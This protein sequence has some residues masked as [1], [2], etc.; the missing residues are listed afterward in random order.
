MLGRYH[1]CMLAAVVCVVVFAA[2]PA[3]A[4]NGMR[5]TG[6]TLR[7]LGRGGAFLATEP[8]AGALNGN[9]GALGMLGEP[10]LFFDV[11]LQ[12][13]RVEYEGLLNAHSADKMLWIPNAGY[14]APL[15]DKLA[16][17][18]GVF[19]LANQSYALR[20]FDLSLLGAPPGTSDEASSGVRYLAITPGIAVKLSEDT[21]VGAALNW[22]SG[23]T[24][25][26]TYNIFGDT[27]G[28]RLE[29]LAG[30]GYS[31]RLGVYHRMD[32]DTTLGAYWRSRSHLDTGNGTMHT[33]PLY[34]VPGA[35]IEGVEVHGGDFPEEYG[36]GLGR[37]LNDKLSLYAEWRRL[38]WAKVR[39]TITVVPPQG[40]PL[41]FPMHW[42]DQDVYVL[43]A[44]Y[45]PDG[46]DGRLWRAGIN[47]GRSP[48]PDNTLAAIFPTTNELHLSAGY[49]H[50]LNDHWRLITGFNYAL[51]HNQTSSADNPNNLR[52]GGGQPYTVGSS[53]LEFGIG[54]EW[55]VGKKPA[56]KDEECECDCPDCRS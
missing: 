51:A 40:D 16:W 17:G 15:G 4:H 50:P 53:S 29:G 8:D 3:L 13:T 47:Y 39:Q 34:A 43:G 44:E 25:D 52:Y 21:A 12:T 49:E 41:P 37:K 26:Q 11:R 22:S 55:A 7:Q 14:A 31:L 30:E 54:F 24:A 35:T 36:L 32:P 45:A 33:G 2:V 18:V 20:D 9:P 19:S 42:R 38:K 5:N 28:H 23:E 1:C 48:V 46:V 10:E 6:T 56:G 27:V